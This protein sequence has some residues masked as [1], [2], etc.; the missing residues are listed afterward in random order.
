MAA[1]LEQ[2]GLRRLDV[3]LVEQCHKSSSLCPHD[4]ATR[5]R[6]CVDPQTPANEALKRLLMPLA[7]SISANVGGVIHNHDTECLHDLRVALRRTRAVLAQAAEVMPARTTSRYRTEFG[8]LAQKTGRL[9]DLDVFMLEF[10]D[11]VTLSPAPSAASLH[12]FLD[13]VGT[14]QARERQAVVRVLSSSRCKTFL[15]DWNRWL[16]APSPSKSKLSRADRAISDHARSAIRATYKRVRRQGRE[17]NASSPDNALH[18]LRKSCKALRYSLELY[19]SL[20]PKR[21]MDVAVTGL[22]KLQDVLGAVQDA[23]VQAPSLRSFAGELTDPDS[24]AAIES[25]V[26][27]RERRGTQARLA[28]ASRFESFMSGQVRLAFKKLTS[29]P[30]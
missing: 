11:R 23:A 19:A 28:F 6:V 27:D 13:L 9:R 25:L 30:K 5:L 16:V 17:I 8:W 2:L 10:D 26:R 1:L 18:K 12:P 15:S 21:R 22:K 20:F 7:Q 29:S 14:A 3:D 24:Q 4:R